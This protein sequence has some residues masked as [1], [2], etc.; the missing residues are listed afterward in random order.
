M[1]GSDDLLLEIEE[2]KIMFQLVIVSSCKMP[3]I[4]QLTVFK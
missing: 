2:R 1:N 4:L 3:S